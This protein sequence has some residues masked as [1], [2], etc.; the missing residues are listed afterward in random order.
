MSCCPPSGLLSLAVLQVAPEP[1]TV[2]LLA[3][4][5]RAVLGP[6]DFALHLTGSTGAGKSELA[7]LIQ[8][9]FGAGFDGRHL[10]GSWSS[11]ANALEA[12]AFSAA[13][14]VLVVDDF[15][16]TAGA[17]DVDRAHRDADRL[18]RAQGNRSGR[19]R[20]RPDGSLRATKPPRGP[21]VSTGEDLPR[22]Q[23]LR[24]RVLVVDVGRS[25]VDWG[26][27]TDCQAHAGAGHLAQALAGFLR[28]MA[29]RY[30]AT[31]SQFAA[32]PELRDRAA[33]SG[34]HRRTPATPPRT[35]SPTSSPTP[36]ASASP[37]W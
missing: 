17:G 22:G 15:A 11:T 5:Y 37:P 23:S 1:V 8:R 16:P 18:L 24:P 2:P 25:D 33:A 21:I 31:Q 30:E 34:E 3:A 4:V 36:P 9:H 28:W 32:L 14:A 13:D 19:L 10:P 12:L 35:W 29:G 20:M 6:C 27:L 26:R 7:A